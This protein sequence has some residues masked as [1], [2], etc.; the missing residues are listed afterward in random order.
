[1]QAVLSG[2]GDNFA[3]MTT[4][5][6]ISHLDELWISSIHLSEGLDVVHLYLGFGKVWVWGFNTTF[7]LLL[8]ILTTFQA[9]HFMWLA[10][11]CWIQC[12]YLAERY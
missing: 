10:I 4:P 9:L 8:E 1:M 6:V 3:D 2:L 12:F 11:R 7:E 5:T